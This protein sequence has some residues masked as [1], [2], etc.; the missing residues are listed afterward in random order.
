MPSCLVMLCSVDITGRPTLLKGNG[1]ALDLGER[2]G[3]G[4]LGG[5]KGGEVMVGVYCMREK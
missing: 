1:G 4:E 5:K 2:G 3:S